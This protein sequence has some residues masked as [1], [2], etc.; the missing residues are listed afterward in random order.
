MKQ[1]DIVFSRS[2]HFLFSLVFIYKKSNQTEFLK[3]LKPIGFDS[4]RFFRTK[5]DL[6]WFFPVLLNFFPIF[7]IWIGFSL[8]FRFQAYKIFCSPLAFREF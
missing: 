5:P 3:K 4:V 2:D 7:S 1:W 6:A 8:V